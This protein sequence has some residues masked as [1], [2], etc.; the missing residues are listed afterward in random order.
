MDKKISDKF[1]WGAATSSHQ[2]EGQNYFNDWWSWEQALKVPDQSLLACDHYN[3]FREDF[4][5]VKQ[6]GHNSHRLSLEWSRLEPKE[7]KWD[8]NAWSHYREVL[9]TLNSLG[10]EPFLTLNHFTLPKW[11]A[12]KGGWN[13]LQISNYFENFAKKAVEKLGNLV[14]YWLTLNEPMVLAI[15]SYLVGIWPPGKTSVA[16]MT[17]AIELQMEAHVKAYRV[18]HKTANNIHHKKIYVGIAKNVAKMDPCTDGFIKNIL[19]TFWRHH[20]Y[21]HFFI[22]SLKHGCIFFPGL[23][24]KILPLRGSL[25]F[26]GLNYYR[27]FHIKYAGL[28]LKKM[29]GDDCLCL[30]H[31]IGGKR[32][33][34]WWESYAQG[35]YDLI[36]EFSRYH[37]PIII[38]ENGI[39]TDDDNQR[40]EFIKEHLDAVAKAR[41]DGFLVKGYFYWSLMDNFE[42]ADGFQP[43]FG[44]VKIDYASLQRMIR[45]SAYFYSDYIKKIG[46]D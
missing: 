16:N 31:R 3:R 46:L 37:L 10:I 24:F 42:W 17:K 30:E 35:L 45:Q 29:L 1:L 36:K 40:I 13:Y 41:A 43:H 44:L 12:D 25:D 6:L 26:I 15:L 18:M 5:I 11:L 23:F 20:F 34:L 14:T 22:W 19:P 33:D 32:T 9:S 7:N 27:R 28:T 39:A 2:V 21:N 8:E 4:R 38:T